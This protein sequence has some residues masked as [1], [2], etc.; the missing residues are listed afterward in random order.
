MTCAK[1]GPGSTATLAAPGSSPSRTCAGTT[2][3]TE[4]TETGDSTRA[5][6]GAEIVDGKRGF[7]KDLA[8]ERLSARASA[9]DAKTAPSPASIVSRATT[10]CIASQDVRDLR[11]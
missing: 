4:T 7:A 5:G 1:P 3:P 9:A 11:K 8:G 6:R 2:P 10:V